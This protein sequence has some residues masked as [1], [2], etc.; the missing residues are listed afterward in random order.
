MDMKWRDFIKLGETAENMPQATT[1]FDTL[2]DNVF[3][4][5]I[6]PGIKRVLAEIPGGTLIPSVRRQ[7]ERDFQ[8]R[9]DKWYSGLTPERQQRFYDVY[10]RPGLW[11]RDQHRRIGMT[12][13]PDIPGGLNDQT[14]NMVM[15]MAA[16]IKPYRPMLSKL[17]GKAS[18]AT[19]KAL[20]RQGISPNADVQG[21]VQSELRRI[22]DYL[23]SEI[24]SAE[25]ADGIFEGNQ[26]VKNLD[27]L[28]ELNPSLKNRV[29]RNLRTAKPLKEGK[30]Y[31]HNDKSIDPDLMEYGDDTWNRYNNPFHSANVPSK[32]KMIGRYGRLVDERVRNSLAYQRI[33]RRFASRLPIDVKDGKASPFSLFKIRQW[34]MSEAERSRFRGVKQRRV[35][36]L[37][38]RTKISVNPDRA[39]HGGVASTH[40]DYEVTPKIELELR[41]D[42]KGGYFVNKDELRHEFGHVLDLHGT[43]DSGDFISYLR[44]S[45]PVGLINQEIRANKIGGLSKI[46]PWTDTYYA[47]SKDPKLILEAWKRYPYFKKPNLPK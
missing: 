3:S 14:L 2:S 16:G 24:G 11:D 13:F 26:V 46:T 38:N 17:P 12:E 33:S 37:A 36:D 22:E 39:G 25:L 7:A 35:S 21:L 15:S 19:A 9:F 30:R 8:E 40:S 20:K 6:K 18:G 29:I 44:R 34:L 23:G 5:Y 10:F 1:G 31:V 42:P 4:N 45:S 47:N 28:G 41:K 27:V 43:E 32:G